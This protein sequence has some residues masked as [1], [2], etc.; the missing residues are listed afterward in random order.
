MKKILTI[1]GFDPSGGAG[2]QA[3]LKTFAVHKTYGMSVVTSIVVQNTRGVQWVEPIPPSLI[4]KQLKVILE[5]I[6]P[7]AIKIGLISSVDAIQVIGQILQKNPP[8]ILVLDPVT[9]SSS[10]YCMVLDKTM[11]SLQNVLFPL[12]TVVTPNIP[13]AEEICGFHIQNKTDMIKAARNI[14]KITNGAVLLKGGHAIFLED[15]SDVLVDQHTIHWFSSP[16]IQTPHTHGTG[17]TLSSAIA[18]HLGKG[19]SLMTAVEKAKVYVSNALLHS[20][21]HPESTVGKGN[22]PLDHTYL[23]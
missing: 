22:S 18:A 19:D 20:I 15:S 14:A 17:C 8:F 13:E 6:L 11:K 23:L 12:S 7:D 16:R 4:Q 5:D 2:L 21:S 9:I 1:A 3:D 10:G